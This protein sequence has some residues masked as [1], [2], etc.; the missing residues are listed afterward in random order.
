MYTG[1]KKRGRP[2]DFLIILLWKSIENLPYGG[3]GIVCKNNIDIR[4]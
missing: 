1:E 3:N 2:F 4:D